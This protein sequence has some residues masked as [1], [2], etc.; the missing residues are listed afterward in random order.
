[1]LHHLPLSLRPLDPHLG[2][3]RLLADSQRFLGVDALVKNLARQQDDIDNIG[4]GAHG[5][6]MR[7]A[8]AGWPFLLQISSEKIV[9]SAFFLPEIAEKRSVI[10][11]RTLWQR[12]PGTV[13]D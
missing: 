1:L 4:A 10:Q 3:L 5:A 12:G 13:V 11:Q 6:S 7:A 8:I 9:E 2:S